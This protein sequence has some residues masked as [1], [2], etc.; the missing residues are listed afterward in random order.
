MLSS[1]RYLPFHADKHIG[2]SFFEAIHN[3]VVGPANW[4][5]LYL[6]LQLL[7]DSGS[8]D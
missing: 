7:C 1:D 5:Y 2:I 4:D 3:A 6:L 8:E